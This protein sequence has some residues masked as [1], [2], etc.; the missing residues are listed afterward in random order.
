MTTFKVAARFRTV[1]FRAL[2]LIMFFLTGACEAILS[3]NQQD[4]LPLN[5]NTTTPLP[6]SKE[7]LGVSTETANI[8][9]VTGVDELSITG[10]PDWDVNKMYEYG[11]YMYG[12]FCAGCHGR[13]GQGVPFTSHFPPLNDST[14]ATSEDISQ[15]LLYMMNTD[16]HSNATMLFEKD[17]LAVI[18]YIR[19]TFASNA[20]L[21][22]PGE[23]VIEI[24]P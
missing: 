19:I 20:D 23:Y 12:R 9:P 24:N 17:A 16:I 11:E 8:I 1:L 5:S 18:N 6:P 10:C 21:I 14:L 15:S 2:F 13:Q 22:C 3:S 7:V 4:V